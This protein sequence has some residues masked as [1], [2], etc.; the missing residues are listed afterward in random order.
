MSRARI[1]LHIAFISGL[2]TFLSCTDN[3]DDDCTICPEPDPVVAAAKT[4]VNEHLADY[5]LRDRI[6]ALNVLSVNSFPDSFD[7]VNFYQTYRG[8]HV[9]QAYL[10]VSV[11][12]V[13]EIES[14][15]YEIVTGI[16]IDTKPKVSSPY[17]LVKAKTEFGRIVPNVEQDG[18]G[19]LAV[20]RLES[21]DFL[22]W[23]FT[24]KSGSATTR[25]E[26]Y[27]NARTGE[28][29]AYYLIEPLD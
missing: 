20:Y 17:A 6:D 13:F 22:C 1:L 24:L 3:P 10:S 28:L 11:N 8:V 2:T 18:N 15:T 25:G 7:M 26:Y 9:A 12:H 21:T 23:H 4:Y 27:I 29:L 14:V 19:E 16:E 5:G